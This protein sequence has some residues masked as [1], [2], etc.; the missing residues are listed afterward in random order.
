MK[1]LELRGNPDHR[2]KFNGKERTEVFGLNMDDFGWRHYD[3]ARGRWNVPDLLSEDAFSWSPYRAFFNNPLKYT[4][5]DGLFEID[6]KTEKMYPELAEYLK[7]VLT[8]YNNKSEDFKKAFMETSGLNEKEVTNLLTY[9]SGPKLEVTNLDEDRNGDG[10][11]NHKKVN[12]IQDKIANGKNITKYKNGKPFGKG[13]VLIDDDVVNIFTDSDRTSQY[14]KVK[15]GTQLL[16]STIFH[17]GTHFGNN[18]KNRNGN[19]KYKESG[20]S[21]ERRVYGRDIGRFS[22]KRQLSK[23]KPLSP[24]TIKPKIHI[25]KINIDLQ[26]KK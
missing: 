1:G 5:P 11:I 2:F 16:E 23:V 18:L 10:K 4:D 22:T 15:L 20:K 9:G 19:G 25:Q 3:P 14:K 21:F 24:Q 17:E 26:L 6:S 8:S 12:G 13:L 7:N